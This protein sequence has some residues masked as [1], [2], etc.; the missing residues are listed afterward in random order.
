M[1]PYESP[2]TTSESAAVSSR[3]SVVPASRGLRFAN[4]IVD[5]I[6]FIILSFV[7]GLVLGVILVVTGGPEA[8]DSID[9]VPDILIGLPVYLFYFISLEGLTGRTLG[10]LLTGTKVVNAKGEKPSFAQICG[11]SLCR[12]IPFE[13]FSF[14]FGE[15]ARG[16]H[17]SLSGTYVVKDR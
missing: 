8:V 6:G 15:V 7:V 1:N 17:D 13:P 11:R 5:Y 4:L 16:W 14:L 2:T 12:I 9:K 10:K 3:A